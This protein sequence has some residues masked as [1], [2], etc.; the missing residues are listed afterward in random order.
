MHNVGK[1]QCESK[2]D[3]TLSWRRS[4]DPSLPSTQGSGVVQ[5]KAGPHTHTHRAEPGMSECLPVEQE[6]WIMLCIQHKQAPGERSD[7]TAVKMMRRVRGSLAFPS[8][9]PPP[10]FLPNC[11]L[12]GAYFIKL[13]TSEGGKYPMTRWMGGEKS[14]HCGGPKVEIHIKLTA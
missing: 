7:R 8:F 14:F 4:W 5:L 9:S 13:F 2:T 10:L 6:T 3:L 11:K 12:K 1:F